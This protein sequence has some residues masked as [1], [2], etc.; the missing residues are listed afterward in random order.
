MLSISWFANQN[1]KMDSIRLVVLHNPTQVGVSLIQS[2]S[3]INQC[4]HQHDDIILSSSLTSVCACLFMFLCVCS[5]SVF[6]CLSLSPS[7]CLFLSCFLPQRPTTV[8]E[9]LLRHSL[10]RHMQIT[11]CHLWSVRMCTVVHEQ[12]SSNTQPHVKP[13]TQMYCR[14]HRTHTHTHTHWKPR[15]T[16]RHTD[17]YWALVLFPPQSILG[18]IWL[19]ETVTLSFN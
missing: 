9:S 4:S 10:L 1:A 18:T 6:C 8:S 7:L 15:H 5:V 19:T 14:T 2:E 13:Q 12:H 3:I 16:H 17:I 11:G